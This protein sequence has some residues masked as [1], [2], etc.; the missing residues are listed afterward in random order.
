MNRLSLIRSALVVSLMAFVSTVYAETPPAKNAPAASAKPTAKPA[1]TPAATAA[2]A[3]APAAAANTFNRLMKAQGKRN[4][5]PAEDGIHDPENDGTTALLAPLDSFSSLPKSMS[6]NRVNWMAALTQNKIAPRYDLKDPKAEAVIMDLN[7][8]REVKGTMPD[9]VFPHKAHTELLDC[10]NCHP[11]VFVPQ[12][13]GNQMSMAAIMLGQG[14]GVCHGK[15]A[16]PVAD[17]RACHSKAKAVAAK[18][19][20]K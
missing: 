3:T 17:C 15:V 10:S 4:P 1:A 14:C 20:G 6:G 12:K 11:A 18:A 16:F 7:I 8:V 9:V 19:G 13:G 5:P 2:T